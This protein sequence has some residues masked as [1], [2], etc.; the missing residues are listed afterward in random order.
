[1]RFEAKIPLQNENYSNHQ[2]LWQQYL[3]RIE[4]L[5][6]ESK[7]S[8]FCMDAGFV[9]VVEVGQYFMTKDIGDLDNFVQWLVANT[10]FPETIQ[11]HKQK[12]GFKEI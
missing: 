12:D 1:M 7:V 5:S 2:N 4:S 10:L 8:K 9:R 11:L 6:Q 3:E